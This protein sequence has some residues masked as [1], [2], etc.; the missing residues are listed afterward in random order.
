MERHPLDTSRRTERGIALIIVIG[1]IAILS[2]LGAVVLSL[3]GNE[4]DA[5]WKERASHDVFYTA[6]R[7][8]EYSLSR[9][10]LAELGE[11][12]DEVNLTDAPHLQNILGDTSGDTAWGTDLTSG[13][14][15]YEGYGGN[16]LKAAKYEKYSIS[17]NKTYRYF[18]VSVQAEHNN[19]QVTEKAS[20]DSEMVMVFVLPDGGSVVG[21]VGSDEVGAG[22]N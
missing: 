8:V 5:S 2:I 9:P 10:V 17:A 15:R 19:K 14:V 13:V 12:G 1:F 21:G 7:A 4:M 22:G 20:V 3:T 6:D 16:P 18:H 11:V